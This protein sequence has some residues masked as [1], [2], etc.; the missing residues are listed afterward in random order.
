MPMKPKSGAEKRKIKE[1]GREVIAKF[2]KISSYLPSASNLPDDAEQTNMSPPEESMIAEE[3]LDEQR[4]GTPPPHSGVPI[5]VD[6]STVSEVDVLEMPLPDSSIPKN[7]SVKSLSNDLG[8][9][10]R[11]TDLD[12]DFW[13]LKA[14][15]VVRIMAALSQHLK[16]SLVIELAVSQR[17]IFT[18]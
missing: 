1:K 2:P 8:L 7:E 3:N 6:H 18:E 15:L 5:P 4:P 12:I 11:I 13:V 17:N 9:W 10:K 14:H 16:V